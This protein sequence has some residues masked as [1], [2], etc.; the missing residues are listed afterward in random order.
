[1]VG[2]PVVTSGTDI[3]MGLIFGIVNILY[4]IIIS[5]IAIV[6]TMLDKKYA[7]KGKWRIPERTL[8]LVGILGG[9]VAMY[10]TMKTIRHKTRH[11]L[12]MTGLPIVIAVH[13][14]LIL[15]IPFLIFL[16]VFLQLNL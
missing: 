7:E 3:P 9:A 1:M 4:P 14:L 5:V 15:G 6:M 2:N 10:I 11:K 16:N 12:F 13:I 8:F